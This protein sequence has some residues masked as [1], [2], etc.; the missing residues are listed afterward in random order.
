MRLDPRRLYPI[1]TISTLFGHPYTV[2]RQLMSLHW[3]SKGRAG[4]NMVTA[5]QGG[6]NFGLTKMP[7]SEAR[8]ARAAEFAEVVE[9]LWQSFPADALLVDREGGRYTDTDLIHPIDHV[10]RHYQVQGPLNLPAFDGPRIPLMQAGGSDSGLDFAAGMADMVFA[11]TPDMDTALPMRRTLSAKAVAK[12]RRPADIRLLPA[13][14]LYLARTRG[15]AQA[16][17]AA[18]HQRVPRTQRVTRLRTLIGLD[19]TDWDDD[20]PVRPSDL[21]P[22]LATGIH[23]LI[24]VHHPTVAELLARPEVLGIGHWQIIGT[25][26]DAVAEVS[27]WYEAGAIDGFIAAPG[28]STMSLDLTLDQVIPRLV[29]AELF[30]K[31]YTCATL[32]G[33]LL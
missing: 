22:A 4:W 19:V 1:T 33:H 5:L 11:Q 8:Y 23:A 28:G 21:T 13:L 14:S 18:N 12:G 26:E 3:L 32:A 25:P 24:A 27:R 6:E 20:R 2:A 7:S 15:E 17:F 30:R 29:S 31:G 16:L 9:R 10:G